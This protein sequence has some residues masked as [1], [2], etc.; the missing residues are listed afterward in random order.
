[1]PSLT[2]K[3]P[4]PLSAKSFLEKFVLPALASRLPPDDE[5]EATAFLNQSEGEPPTIY[6]SYRDSQILSVEFKRLDAQRAL[7]TFSITVGYFLQDLNDAVFQIGPFV[8]GS[9]FRLNFDEALYCS[10]QISISSELVIHGTDTDLLTE[11]LDELVQLTADL[12]WFCALR[13]PSRLSFMSK[14]KIVEV[15][16][17]H[18][19]N[20]EGVVK[21]L[22]DGLAVPGGG[23]DPEI[24]ML[25]AW[26]LGRW[27][28]LLRVLDEYPDE[29]SPEMAAPIR[30]RAL[31]ELGRWKASLAAAR[32]A[33]IVDGSY[34]GA[35]RLSPGYL[36]ALIESGDEIE[37]L[38]L[39][40]RATEG[41]P[42]FYQLLRGVARH[43]A[44]DLIG[45][46]AP[47]ESYFAQWP[48][49]LAAYEHLD[50]VM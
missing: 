2:K 25:L 26:A 17:A 7:L 24:L 50:D 20:P 45:S 34:P 36:Q 13:I 46:R 49:D 15:L 48:G 6:G 12:D 31:C 22:E 32:V 16:E 33:G 39:L 29:I 11:R 23:E 4:R 43:A 3:K 9:S 47:L 37:A 30:A 42:G 8:Q 35:T 21:F 28:D 19:L 10:G 5:G 38:R 14:A 44:G 41:E 40:G 27:T 1:M 18:Q